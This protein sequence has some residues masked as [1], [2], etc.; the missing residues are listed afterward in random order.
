MKNDNFKL[1]NIGGN[2][3]F[4]N[5]AFLVAFFIFPLFIFSFQFAHADIATSLISHWKMDETSGTTAA[6]SAGT[7]NGTI[8]GATFTAGKIGNGLS[9]N[10][11][12]DYVSVPRM[13]YD[14]ITVSAWFYKNANDTVNADAIFG[15]WYWNSNAQ[16]QEGFDLRFY[17]TA[18][19]KLDFIIVTTNGAVKTYKVSS[20]NLVNSAGTWHH[21]TA[22]YNKTTGEQKLYV[23]GVLRDTD[24]HPAGNTIVPYTIN[25]D[26]RIGYSRI[27]NGYFNGL[28]DDI[29]VYSRALTAADITELYNYNGSCGTSSSSSIQSSSSSVQ[30]APAVTTNSAT[31]ITSVSTTLNATV[32]N[33]G[34]TATAWFQYGVD[35]TMTSFI[36]ITSSQTVSDLGNI[37]VSS[38]I[39]SLA[40]NTVYYYRVAAQSNAGTTYGSAQTFT[41]AAVS[42]SPDWS[43][44]KNFYAPTWGTTAVDFPAES[45]LYA[46]QMGYDYIALRA[47][48]ANRTLYK[49][50]PDRAGLKFYFINPDR[51]QNLIPLIS[52]GEIDTNTTYT[53]AQKDYIEKYFVW[54]S[55]DAFPNNI[56]SGWF[57]SASKF[58]IHWDF[59]QQAVI[60]YVIDQIVNMAK[61]Y[62]TASQSFTFAGYMVDVPRLAGDFSYWD[63]NTSSDVYTSLNYW[64][65]SDS[66]L[67]HGTVT[68]EYATYSEAYVAFYKQLNT[69]MRQ[70]WPDAKWIL[71][72]YWMYTTTVSS[73]WISAIK[74]RSDRDELT[75]DMLSQESPTTEFVDDNRIFNSGVNIT[76]DRVGISHRKKLEEDKNRL[77]AA[78]AGINGA[79]Y[80]WFGWFNDAGATLYFTSIT[81]VYPRL[82]LIRLIPNWDNLRNI[83]LAQRTWNNSTTDPIYSSKKNTTDPNPTS[84]F[85]SHVMYSRQWK[86]NKLFAVFNDAITPIKLNPGE[87]IS[88][89]QC[90]DGYFIELGDCTSNFTITDTSSG[91][92]IKLNSNIVIPTDTTNGQIKGMGY[93]ITTGSGSSSSSSSIPTSSSSATQSSSSSSQPSSS[94]SSVQSST[95]NTGGGGGGG[96]GGIT[97]SQSSST[98][99][100]GVKNLRA[101]KGSVILEWD[102]INTSEA[103]KQILIYRNLS[104]YPVQSDTSSLIATL[105]DPRQ[106]SYRDINTADN[107][108]YYY[109]VFTVDSQG[110]SSDPA[111]ISFNSNSSSALIFTEPLSFGSRSNQVKTLQ[112]KLSA[113]K[114]LYPEGLTTGYYGS[115][116][117]A[118]V[119]RFQKKHNLETTGLADL[120]TRAKLNEIY[121]QTSAAR[122]PDGQ[123]QA[124]SPQASSTTSPKSPYS[125]LTEAQRQEIIKQLQATLKQLLQQLLELLKKQAGI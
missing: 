28:L 101:R 22:T 72:P 53:Q 24:L 77:Y 68:Y 118:A 106:T 115:L 64:T 48:D 66:G 123:G 36:G 47:N 19:D 13:N 102:S 9:F 116:T 105:S 114:T 5:F 46:K 38:A 65:G 39:S 85:D 54:K 113:D 120:K 14:E 103:I 96:G 99:R 78:K 73:G 100:K 108:T 62:E 31:S 33:N 18:P 3:K 110:N 7:N 88:S 55:M 109:S 17:Q 11:T 90:T 32:N 125:S 26:M 50:N 59:Q 12:S 1:K 42:S 122:L 60:D 21:V 121:G 94:S 58:Q 30:S 43:S 84:Y 8:T 40:A 80:N 34:L 119:K 89:I 92:Q 79:W 71:E 104:Y 56:A 23:D 124:S 20:Y 10:G 16:L 95:G 57:F 41:T 75:P 25:T 29:C 74:D 93:I 15:G 6:D 82:K 107:L 86:N 67:V 35:S 98:K 83:P 97:S 37:A 81:E 87:T 45:I 63:T 91:K 49:S 51:L 27:N 112:E 44:W 69:R 117:Q 76:K 2:I 111:T 70:E 4:K 61:S 52:R